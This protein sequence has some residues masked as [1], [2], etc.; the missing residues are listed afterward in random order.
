MLTTSHDCLLCIFAYFCTMYRMT[1][2]SVEKV[3]GMQPRKNLCWML[4]ICS[5][6]EA[7]TFVMLYHFDVLLSIF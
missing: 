1:V 7:G 5:V 3:H 4:W 2:F 6:L